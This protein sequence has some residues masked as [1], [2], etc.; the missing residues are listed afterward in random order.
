M[1]DS[2]IIVSISISFISA[3]SWLRRDYIDIIEC[4]YCYFVIGDI[5]KGND[6]FRSTGE[7]DQLN[8][9]GGDSM[10]LGVKHTRI[11]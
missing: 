10:L 8:Q 7:S 9:E 4:H 11:L 1:N 6:S 3:S 2:A 5:K